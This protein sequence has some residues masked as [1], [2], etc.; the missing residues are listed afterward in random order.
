M[1]TKITS[2]R[3]LMDLW[4]ST[5]E[6]ALDLGVRKNTAE[7]M[8][9]RNSVDPTYWGRIVEGAKRRRIRNV[10]LELLVRLRE[11]LFTEKKIASRPQAAA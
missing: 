10:K 7:V 6:F 2:F 1:S 9:F 11:E 5:A 3:D 8:R 4:P